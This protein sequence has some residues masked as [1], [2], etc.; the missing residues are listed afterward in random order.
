MPLAFENLGAM[1]SSASDFVSNVGRRIAAISGDTRETAFL[2]QRLSVVLQRY[3]A[4]LFSD[5]F[6]SSFTDVTFVLRLSY[7]FCSWR[8]A[9][10]GH[11]SIDEEDR[12]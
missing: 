5:T 3:N 6:T 12:C 9:P 2:F 7:R 10:D 8:T 1:D 11:R 4:V